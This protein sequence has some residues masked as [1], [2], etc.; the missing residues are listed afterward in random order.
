MGWKG[1]ELRISP[2]MIFRKMYC[3]KCGSKLKIKKV[4]ETYK[5]GDP[6]YSN[7]ILGHSTIGMNRKEV[8]RY[9]YKCPGCASEITYEDQCKIAKRK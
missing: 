8:V 1:Y 7:E 2:L 6:E 3:H 4:S 9:I 5:K